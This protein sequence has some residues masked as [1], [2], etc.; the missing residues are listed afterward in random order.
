MGTLPELVA[1]AA[2]FNMQVTRRFKF[3]G[4]IGEPFKAT[5]GL[6]QGCPL[7]IDF[8]N[9]FGAVW[10]K[11]I[12]SS[13]DAVC[14]T[15]YIDDRSLRGTDGVQLGAALN[16]TAAFDESAGHKLNVTKS[17]ASATTRAGRKEV[18]K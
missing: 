12:G 10:D 4:H 5:G 7:S 14:R 17:G 13:Y 9:Q 6:G 2:D 1:M 8:A 15:I 3:A 18:Q 11:W 16:A